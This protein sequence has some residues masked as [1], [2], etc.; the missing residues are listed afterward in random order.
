MKIYTFRQS[1]EIPITLE[2]AWEFFSNP[3]NLNSITPPGLDFR[4]TSGTPAPMHEGQVITYK[5]RIAPM[6]WQTWVTEIKA[7]TFQSQ[8][9][10]EQRGGPYKFWHH[11][12]RFESTES[13]T[14][15]TDEVNYAL[16]FYLLGDIAHG[17]FVKKKLNKIFEYRKEILSKKFG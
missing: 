13:G 1:Q 15:I 2:K 8:F 11:C 4:I 5:I 10:D 7:V 12:H 9:I 16:P 3:E 14:L 17:L 6:I